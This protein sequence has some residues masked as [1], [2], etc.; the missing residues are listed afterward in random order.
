MKM[1]RAGCCIAIAV[2]I[3]A[4]NLL[5]ASDVEIRYADTGRGHEQF[6]H[7]APCSTD[8]RQGYKWAEDYSFNDEKECFG[9][10]SDFV[11][12]CRRFVREAL[13]IQAIEFEL[14]TPRSP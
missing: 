13:E 11:D 7:E 8:C 5:V 9:A 2:V 12:G 4:I 1:L 3:S 10:A 14:A 6:S